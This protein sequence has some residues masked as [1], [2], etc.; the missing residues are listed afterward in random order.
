MRTL[1]PFALL[2]LLL[3]V[4]VPV[5]GAGWGGS[6]HAAAPAI[7]LNPTAILLPSGSVAVGGS[8]FTPN[9]IVTLKVD[10]AV[11]AASVPTDGSGSFAATIAVSNAPSGPHTVTA[12]DAANV[13]A[14]QTL[15]AVSLSLSAASAAPGAQLTIGG[16]GFMPSQPLVVY[17]GGQAVLNTVTDA[18]G[19]FANQALTVPASLSGPQQLRV[20][21]GAAGQV[22]VTTSITV[23]QPTI[24]LNPNILTGA[25]SVA[26]SGAGF[27]PNTV[28]IL[29]LDNTSMTLAVTT[30]A[31]GTFGP[32]QVNVPA[33]TAGG[34]HTIT[35]IDSARHTLASA[36]LVIN[37]QPATMSVTPTSGVPGSQVTASGAG[38][39]ANEPITLGIGGNSV[40]GTAAN[41]QGQFSVTFTLPRTLSAGAMSLQATGQSSHASATAAFTIP[42]A[43]LALSAG[44]GPAGAS[45][46]VTGHN[47]AA[48]EPITVAIAGVQIATATSDGSGSFSATITIPSGPAGSLTVTAGGA[49]SH[50]SASATFAR[51]AV[52]LQAGAAA[53]Q[54][55]HAVTLSGSGFLPNEPVAITIP[56]STLQ[57][58]NANAQGGFSTALIIPAAQPSGNLTISAA[59]QS[60][61]QT[62]T[63]VVAV[64]SLAH[65]S[66]GAAGAAQGGKVTVAGQG[67]GPGEPVVLA[68]PGF[69]L[70]TVSANAQGSFSV[71]I[72]V[73]TG[74]PVSATTITATG[75]GTH[76]VATAA[77]L[78]TRAPAHLVLSVGAVLAGSS[79]MVSGSGFQPNEQV[80]IA[81]AGRTLLTLNANGSGAFSNVPLT[82]P[83]VLLPGLLTLNATGSSSHQT[84]SAV[85][86]VQ[87][88]AAASLSVS[89]PTF[90]VGT[91]VR[92]AGSGFAPGEQV[93]LSL[94][95]ATFATARTGSAGGFVL[96]IVLPVTAGMSGAQIVATGSV[97]NVT[98]SATVAIT[99]L[100]PLRIGSTSWYYAAGRTDAGFSEQIAILN[101]NLATAHGT[102]TF[103]YGA[104][105][106]KVF[107]FTLRPQ[108]RGTYDVGRSIGVQ[109]GVAAMV[110]SDV[111]VAAARTTSRGD[112]DRMAT[113]G[114]SAP[115]RAWYMAEG[116][117]GL[118]FREDL[119][120]LNP[121]YTTAHVHIV[122]PLFNGR[123]PVS[124]D[125]TMAPRSQ[126][127]VPVNAYVNRASHA[128]I[129]SAD[130]PIVASRTLLFGAGQQGADSKAGMTQGGTTLHFAEGSTNNGFEEYLTILNP[131][132]ARQAQVTAS[133]YDRQ[134]R[135][136]GTRVIAIDPLHRGNIKVNDVVRAT[137]VSTVLHSSL[138]IVA[139]RAM[140]F[141]APNGGSSG[142]TVVFGR[143]TP[144]QGWAFATGD[145][146]PGHSEFELL[147]NPNPTSSTI[148]A[149][150]YAD[151]GQAVR[152]TFT[153]P[154]NA[155]LNIDVTLMVPELARGYHGVVLRTLNGVS[156]IAEQ[157]IYGNNMSNGSATVGTPAA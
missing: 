69:V 134:G 41:G 85:L 45:V 4:L 96:T 21:S 154:G 36:V 12:T 49:V 23:G 149:V 33:G 124:H 141:G 86:T 16:Q 104:N 139:E 94:N 95:G 126:V 114:V 133:F 151:N 31:A 106:T 39:A 135:L 55:G 37:A 157:A 108:A 147:F 77:L 100:Q 140:Y 72:T 50:A 117:T 109:S 83:A 22:A 116:Y 20:V 66:L 103:F 56:G 136:L 82:L 8:G 74:A 81:A 15:Y 123:P 53:V 137:A 65:I 43:T 5:A 112:L 3:V 84:A 10:A 111:P 61:H 93:R 91:S 97:S 156:F 119:E 40:A 9:S 78:V 122:W 59:G 27:A 76:R 148:E 75:A 92:I 11:A 14:S 42:A 18:A 128:T 30:G 142:G 17:L 62:A 144:A 58:L 64:T 25:G 13:S 1:R 115:A 29:R 130:A 98:V 38:F 145:T 88:R 146:R 32:L 87:P 110:Q 63:V 70:A 47:F 24:T 68:L 105:Q 118:T 150:F 101:P 89:P 125:L 138:P 155:R 90:S 51:A 44:S 121:G 2:A 34:Q 46:T 7:T 143:T 52:G 54:A 71:S 19:S 60:S 28:L 127:L 6:A 152:K 107:S 120:L 26:V 113:T 35:A 79:V 80:V 131:D 132:S 102:I 57:T 153:L 48:G 73:P 99:A 129:V 67:F